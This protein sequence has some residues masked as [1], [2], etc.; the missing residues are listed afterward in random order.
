MI[1]L[2]PYASRPA[3]E[4]GYFSLIIAASEDLERVDTG[5]D[6]ILSLGVP[7]SMAH[8]DKRSLSRVFIV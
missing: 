1:T 4:A 3:G 5:T 8:D 2:I 7:G 6:D